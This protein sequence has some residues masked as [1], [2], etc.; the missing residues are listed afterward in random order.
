M[1]NPVDRAIETGRAFENA[2]PPFDLLLPA[3]DAEPREVGATR[4]APAAALAALRQRLPALRIRSPGIGEPLA[5]GAAYLDAL[6]SA[7]FGWSLSR[8]ASLPLYASDRMAHMA[9]SGLA[10]LIDRRAGF[11]RFYGDHA[12]IF[13]TDLDDLAARIR[14]LLADDAAARDLARHGWEI[15]WRLFDSNRVLAYLLDQLFRGGGARDYDW[16][17]ERWQV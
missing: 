5:F 4:L 10:V 9:G 11:Q 16:P 8:R 12:A 7:R 3:T 1:P 2:A 17:S 15:T 14:P 6:T 13:H